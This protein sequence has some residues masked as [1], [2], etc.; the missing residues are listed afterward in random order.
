MAIDL[1]ILKVRLITHDSF[2][3]RNLMTITKQD[4]QESIERTRRYGKRALAYA[5]AAAVATTTTVASADF[6]GDYAPENWAATN[7]GGSVTNDGSTAVIT[8]PDEGIQDSIFYSIQIA[9]DGFLQFDWE[10]TNLLGDYGSY[11]YAGWIIGNDFTLLATND[12]ALNS[13]AFGSESISVQQGQFFSF[14]VTSF[15][16]EF[17][18]GQLTITNF[19]AVVPEPSAMGILA[20]GTIGGLLASR[21]R[22]S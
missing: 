7:T 18:A 11:D 13:P 12:D 17:G 4:V 15:D 5:A 14:V 1:V 21:R 3:G 2:L 22:K 20:A 10:Y 6:T 19:D 16:G 9:E 8:G